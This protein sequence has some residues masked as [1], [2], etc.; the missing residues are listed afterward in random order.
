MTDR[1]PLKIFNL[2]KIAAY[3]IDL[4]ELGPDTDP[5]FYNIGTV[6]NRLPTIRYGMTDKAAELNT[7]AILNTVEQTV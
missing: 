3:V 4:N 6:L 2:E 5:E 7:W 1:G